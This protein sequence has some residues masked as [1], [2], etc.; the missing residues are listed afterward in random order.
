MRKRLHKQITRIEELI[1]IKKPVGV[2]TIVRVVVLIDVGKGVEDPLQVGRLNCLRRVN[3]RV[4]FHGSRCVFTSGGFCAVSA[5]F[6]RGLFGSGSH[7]SRSH[8]SRSHGSRSHGSSSRGGVSA[9]EV[10]AAGVTLYFG[11]PLEDYFG[12]RSVGDS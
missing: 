8:G 7:G 5:E 11:K 2:V 3:P 4:L 1:I 9:A 6:L 12:K 10:T